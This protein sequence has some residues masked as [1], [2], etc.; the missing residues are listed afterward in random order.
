[1][2]VNIKFLEK[3]GKMLAYYI[4]FIDR[5]ELKVFCG[6]VLFTIKSMPYTVTALISLNTYGRQ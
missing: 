5:V 1:M 4:S 6:N 3:I 2:H